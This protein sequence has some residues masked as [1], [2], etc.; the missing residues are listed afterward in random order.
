MPRRNQYYKALMRRI[1]RSTAASALFWSLLNRPYA[2]SLIIQC[3]CC[4]ADC[5]STYW[6]PSSFPMQLAQQ[7]SNGQCCAGR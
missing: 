2:M 7:D 4:T 3:A 5:L 1:P 6:A